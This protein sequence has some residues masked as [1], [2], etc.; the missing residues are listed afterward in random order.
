MHRHRFWI[1]FCLL[2]LLIAASCVSSPDLKLPAQP[3]ALPSPTPFQPGIDTLPPSFPTFDSQSVLTFTPYPTVVL[4]NETYS[5]PQVSSSG[6][7]SPVVIDP[8]TGLPP[9][10]PSLLQRRP[11]AIKL[12]NFPRY[13]RPQ[14]GLTQAD[15][16]FEY[17]SQQ[18]ETRFIAVF[19]GSNPNMV[20]PVRSGRYFDEHVV[21]MYHAFYVFQYADPRELT[22]FKSGDLNPFLVLQG[23]GKCPPFF[24][25]KIHETYNDAYF[26]VTKWNDCAEQLRRDNTPQTLRG[27]FFNETPPSNM[28]KV[29]RIFTNYTAESYNYWQYDPLSG[30]YLRYEDMSDAHDDQSKQYAPLMDSLT[31]RQVSADTMIVLFVPHTFASE[32]EQQ[33]EVYHIDLIDSGNAFVFRNGMAIPAR[34]YRTDINQ[35]LLI[36][37]LDGSPIY[38][39][40]G[41]TFFQVIGETSTMTQNGTDWRFGFHTP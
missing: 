20:G 5:T 1:L 8:L 11:L 41:Q 24:N 13:V 16:V 36:T 28:P 17:Y 23:A 39:K 15:I 38:V 35:P 34:W 19:Y 22:Y 10:D 25:P 37:N 6:D 30:R 14:Y 32:N 33:D 7:A 27:N 26:D 29:N 12:A 4:E 9:A 18:F 3:D 2:I 21:R 40:P 31:G